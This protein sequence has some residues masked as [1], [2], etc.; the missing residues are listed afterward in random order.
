MSFHRQPRDAHFFCLKGQLRPP[1]AQSKKPA[2][3]WAPLPASPLVPIPVPPQAGLVPSCCATTWPASA[4]SHLWCSSPHGAPTS[5][6]RPQGPSPTQRQPGCPCSSTALSRGCL[7]WLL[8]SRGNL[9]THRG[10]TRLCG[11]VLSLQW[12]QG[13]GLRLGADKDA[14]LMSSSERAPRRPLQG[15]EGEDTH[16]PLGGM[17]PSSSHPTGQ[18]TLTADRRS[19]R[20]QAAATLPQV[21]RK[22]K[23]R[24][25][26]PK[27]RLSPGLGL[28]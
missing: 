1:S 7:A 25:C 11:V 3:L 4:L 20:P 8:Q 2:A 14:A 6:P 12:Q 26:L 13:Q 18:E 16:L 19:R 28:L 5:L 23:L 9:L 24:S 27:R 22:G 17:Q 15:A 10:H 21:P